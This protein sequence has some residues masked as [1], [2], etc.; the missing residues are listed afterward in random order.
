MRFTQSVVISKPS[1][2]GKTLKKSLV[3]GIAVI[4]TLGVFLAGCGSSAKPA[5]PASS[6]QDMKAMGHDANSPDH[7]NM[8]H[9]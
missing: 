5:S 1:R 9:Q 7:K 3:L 8:S 2:G 4:I 6:Q